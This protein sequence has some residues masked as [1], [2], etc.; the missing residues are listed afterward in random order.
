MLESRFSYI[1]LGLGVF[2]FSYGFFRFLFMIV[3][4]IR[5]GKALFTYGAGRGNWAVVTGATDGIGKAL[6]IE[7]AK[8]KFNLDWDRV[9]SVMENLTVSI[10]INCAGLSHEFPKPFE[11]EDEERCDDIIEVNINSLTKMTRLV[12]P[13]MKSRRNG[14][15]L[16]IGSFVSLVPSPYL[17]VYSGSKSFVQSYSAALG[18]ELERF[19]ILVQYVSTYYVV[20]KMSKIRKPNF[21]TPTA[22]VYAKSILSRIGSGCGSL[23]PYTTVPYFSHA[24]IHFAAQNLF[25]PKFWLDFSFNHLEGVRKRALKKQARLAKEAEAKS[26]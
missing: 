5:P 21:T 8:N 25:S 10:L 12:I 14:L 19:G 6:S 16:N 7:L 4:F 22:E 11:T 9:K 24:L 3:D 1:F 15:I 23:Y 2:T 17:S 20:S 26:Q 18:A 13:Q